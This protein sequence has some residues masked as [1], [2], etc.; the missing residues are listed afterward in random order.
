MKD[1][2]QDLSRVLSRDA[3]AARLAQAREALFHYDYRTRELWKRSKEMQQRF[4]DFRDPRYLAHVDIEAVLYFRE[5]QEC[6]VAMPRWQD[7]I[8]VGGEVDLRL[9]LAIGRECFEKISRLLPSDARQRRVLDF[10][11]GC[12]RTARH[13]YRELERFELHGCDVDSSAVGYLFDSVPSIQPVRSSNSPP[14]PYEERFFDAIYCVSVFTHLTMDAF[15]AWMAELTR[16]LAPGGTALITLHGSHA[17]EVSNAKPDLSELGIDTA[18]FR[19]A[20][21]G[22]AKEGFIWVPQ[23][24]GSSDIDATQYGISYVDRTTL[25]RLLPRELELVDYHT[26][27]IGN[28][29]DLAVFR[30]RA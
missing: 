28:W 24:V 13:F 17:L 18:A 20:H 29:Q 14:L 22:F 30:R 23:F 12:A 3:I 15:A 2:T 25:N 26:A 8:T 10:G 6:A 21:G 4:P 27:Q 11:V 7:M 16:C 9:F 19:R 1:S 5:L